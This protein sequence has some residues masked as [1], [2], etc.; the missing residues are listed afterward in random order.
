MFSSTGLV[1]IYDTWSV[2]L[3][4]CWSDVVTWGFFSNWLQKH[5]TLFERE[6]SSECA[7]SG[8]QVAEIRCTQ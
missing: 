2:C 5:V 3:T 8:T 7:S 6:N 1:L 4:N